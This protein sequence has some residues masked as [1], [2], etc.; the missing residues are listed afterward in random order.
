MNSKIS[1]QR[2]TFTQQFMKKRMKSP[3]ILDLFNIKGIA[4]K[5]NR[6]SERI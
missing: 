6:V 5:A 4:K 3:V 1:N 2:K